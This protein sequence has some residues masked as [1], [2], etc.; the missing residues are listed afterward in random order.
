MANP[1]KYKTDHQNI[2]C[3]RC[4]CRRQKRALKTAKFFQ[5]VFCA[6]KFFIYLYI[7]WFCIENSSV[8]EPGP[9]GAATFAGA[10]TLIQFLAPAPAP[11][12]KLGILKSF[13]VTDSASCIF[14][15]G[16]PFLTVY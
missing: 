6:P 2:V 13:I 5:I 7:Y 11:C 1:L 8:V 10:V 12:Y 15:H 3:R 4:Y 16:H 14:V 9:Q